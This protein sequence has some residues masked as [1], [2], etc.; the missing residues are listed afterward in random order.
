M[1]LLYSHEQLYIH[2]YRC[3]QKHNDA[4]KTS[5][6]RS[7]EKYISHFIW[8]GSNGLLKFLLCERW[9]GDWT[10]L[11]H[12]DPT[13]MALTAFS[14]RSPGLLNRRPGGPASL[15]HGPHSSIFSPT[16]LRLWTLT[17]QSEVLKASSAECWFSLQHL[18]SNWPELPVAGV[19]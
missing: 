3:I 12:I 13:L 5:G 10:E 1:L 15:G 17:A 4:M 2:I 14:S 16:D 18:N 6:H 7:L 8:K 19:I 9:A 11:Q